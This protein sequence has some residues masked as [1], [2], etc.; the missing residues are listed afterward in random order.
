MANTVACTDYVFSESHLYLLL[1]TVAAGSLAAVAGTSPAAGCT[2]R[3]AE[4]VSR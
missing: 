3:A 1:S 2:T 4:S